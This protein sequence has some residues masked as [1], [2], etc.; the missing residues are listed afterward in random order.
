V[1]KNSTPISIVPDPQE[2]RFVYHG[3]EFRISD[4]PDAPTLCWK[5]YAGEDGRVVV[6]KPSRGEWE[7]LLPTLKNNDYYFISVAKVDGGY[8][9]P[10]V[11]QVVCSAFHG[12]P[13]TARSVAKHKNDNPGDNR[14]ANLRWGTKSENAKEA[15]AHRRLGT[16]PQEK[17]LSVPIRRVI[18]DRL[19]RI[20]P[21]MGRPF[22][23][24]IEQ[25]LVNYLNCSEQISMIPHCDQ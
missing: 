2:G 19:R 21:P 7:E 22:E 15:H 20:G 9:Q 6:F 25:I 23:E 1:T 17:R 13:P 10:Y 12:A 8:Y 16:S 4:L 3:V 11:Q 18:V 14:A 5:L 24:F